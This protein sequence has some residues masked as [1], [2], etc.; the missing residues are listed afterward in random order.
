MADS[1]EKKCATAASENEIQDKHDDV[2]LIQTFV[3][4]TLDPKISTQYYTVLKDLGFGGI[5]SFGGFEPQ[6]FISILEQKFKQEDVQGVKDKYHFEWKYG[7]LSTLAFYLQMWHN[8][9]K[10][11]AHG[12]CV[13][14]RV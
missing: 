12:L 1:D 4:N 3:Q 2:E 10:N 6:D 7:H 14:N 13:L 11:I 8:Q 9:L 5:Y